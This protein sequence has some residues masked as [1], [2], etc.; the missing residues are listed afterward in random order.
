[1][2]WEKHFEKDIA[3]HAETAGEYDEVVVKPRELVNEFLFR[4]F[5]QDIP[6]GGRMLD[7]G[8]GTGHSIIRFG[9][10]FDSVLGVDH[11]REML[12]QVVVNVE[13]AGI[14]H[15]VLLNQDHYAFLD[16]VVSSRPPPALRQQR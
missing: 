7:L 12:E 11:S 4:D 5:H 1:M 16:G 13:A 8:S 2:G 6:G 9:D 15:D 10:R 3:Y 14:A